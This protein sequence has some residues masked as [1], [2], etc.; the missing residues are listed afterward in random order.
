MIIFIYSCVS[1]ELIALFA[2]YNT[3]EQFIY[4]L[5]RS[6]TMVG[7]CGKIA[8]VIVK[9]KDI[10]RLLNILDTYPCCYRNEKEKL[11]QDKLDKT[12]K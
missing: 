2:S 12:I 10:M 6:L 11:I 1:F 4:N 9:R 8:N 7:V 5:V 3:L